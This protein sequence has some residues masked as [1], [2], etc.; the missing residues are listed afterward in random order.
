MENYLQRDPN[1][2]AFKKKLMFVVVISMA[3]N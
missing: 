1:E 2:N 3:I